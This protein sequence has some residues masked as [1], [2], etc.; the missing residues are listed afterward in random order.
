MRLASFDRNVRATFLT[1]FA[2]GVAYGLSIALTP[3]QMRDLGFSKEQIG[4]MAAWFAG[5]IVAL[6]LPMGGLVRRFTARRTLTAA[7]LGYAGCVAVF[8]LLRTAPQIALARALDGACSVGIWVSCETILLA[9]ARDGQKATVMSIYAVSMGVGYVLGPVL[10][11]TIML[12]GPRRWAFF[13][14]GVLALIAAGIARTRLDADI[15]PLEEPGH[16]H[17][18]A[19]APVRALLARIRMSCLGTF[20]YGYFQ[21]SVVLFLPLYLIESRGVPEDQTIFITAFFASG[22]LLFSNVVGRW[23]D[24]VGH[25]FAM[26]ALAVVGAMMIG[27]FPFLP[28]FTMM[29]GAVFVAGAT[30]ATISP[31]S[32]ALQGV[33]TDTRDYE[34]ANSVYNAFYAAGMLLGPP[35]SSRI[36]A[37]KGGP[38]MLFHLA[39]L[40]FVFALLAVIWRRDDPAAR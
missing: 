18:S 27:G 37:A 29:C 35:I 16:V 36:F 39:A 33:V 13:A 22:M 17:D 31:V 3:L 32:L 34:R 40:W 7:L 12:F 28:T 8:P 23:A 1:I 24:R 20:A 2:L 38:V 21:A 30:L 26:R 14:A 25:L 10:A 19:P 5:G 4:G 6:S 11:R 15:R 9:R